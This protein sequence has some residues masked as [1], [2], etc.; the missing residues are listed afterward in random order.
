[1]WAWCAM[2]I[3][4]YAA[5]LP[6]VPVTRF[7]GAIWECGARRDPMDSRVA[8]NLRAGAHYPSYH[9]RQW[10]MDFMEQHKGDVI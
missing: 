5:A 10:N 3:L 1:M 2:R 8:F 9:N 7:P 4:D 6:V